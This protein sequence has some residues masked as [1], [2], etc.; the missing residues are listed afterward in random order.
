MRHPS[1]LR[2]I[3]HMAVWAAL[4][5]GVFSVVFQILWNL[6]V[7]ELLHLPAITFWQ[8]VSVLLMA[9]LLAGGSTR[10]GF[11]RGPGDPRGSGFPGRFGGPRGFHFGRDRRREVEDDPRRDIADWGHYGAYWKEEGRAAFEQWLQRR[12]TEGESGRSPS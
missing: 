3:L 9:R 11:E 10:R 7:P 1:F 5:I 2:N 8:S 4:G 6:V 12:R